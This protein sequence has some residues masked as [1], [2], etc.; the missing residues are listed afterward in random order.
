MTRNAQALRRLYRRKYVAGFLILA[1]LV[2][3][4]LYLTFEKTSHQAGRA[5]LVSLASGQKALSQRISFFANALVTSTPGERDVIRLELAEAIIQMRRAHD[6][7][8]QEAPST[9]REKAQLQSVQDIYF[10][11]H[12]PFDGEVREFLRAATEILNSPDAA[13]SSNSILLAELN[14]LGIHTIMQ[15]HDVIT[16]IIAH[17]TETGITRARYLQT[18]FAAFILALLVIE[19]ALIFE[20]MGRRIEENVRRAE[21]SERVAQ[22][23]AARAKNARDAKANFLRVMSHELRTP[24]NAVI[25]MSELLKSSRLNPQQNTY[26]RHIADAGQHMLTVANDILTVNQHAIGKLR[27]D[28]RPANLAYEVDSVIGMLSI[29]AQE[30]GLSLEVENRDLLDQVYETDAPRFRQVLI[31]LI[32]NAIKFT[33]TGGIRISAARQD[34]PDGDHSDFQIR[35]SDTGIGI[36]TDKH[37]K[38]FE[39]FE[40]ADV[41]DKRSYGGAG[42]G[43]SISKKIIE[44]LGGELSLEQSNQSG[45]TFLI[46]IRMEK[47]ELSTTVPVAP[48][49]QTTLHGAGVVLVVDDNLPNRMIAGAFLKKSGYDVVYAQ[50]GQEAFE[51]WQTNSDIAAIFMDIE[52]PVMNGETATQKIRSKSTPKSA[53][54]IIALTAHALPEDRERLLATGFDDVLRK[55]ATEMEIVDAA[56][57]FATQR[58]AA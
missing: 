2:C 50:N 51:T 42:L 6:I 16:R 28:M 13:L 19:G 15:T 54:P 27:F 52:M 47:Y 57:R 39:E 20:P 45:S 26:I 33:E 22:E 58:N 35:V 32:G 23:E 53:V 34:T 56:N 31:N 30:N 12:A 55:P 7:L 29:K 36:A 37:E 49:E 14:L 10:N 41:F 43:L 8:A 48:E 24:L 3:A 25:G 1:A 5:E 40:Q 46:Q 21:L 9:A 17:E 4:S 44:G 18:M 38:I 11:D